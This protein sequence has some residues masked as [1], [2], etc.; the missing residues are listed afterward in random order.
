M[1]KTRDPNSLSWMPLNVPISTGI[2]SI[3]KRGF[4]IKEG[5]IKY[6]HGLRGIMKGFFFPLY[7]IFVLFF[8]HFLVVDAMGIGDIIG[9]TVFLMACTLG[10]YLHLRGPILS[11]F[12]IN[13][14]IILSGNNFAGGEP[15]YIEGQQNQIPMDSI[16]KII[17]RENAEKF[18]PSTKTDFG[19]LFILIESSF[20]NKFGNVFVINHFAF[21]Q[22]H[23]LKDYLDGVLAILGNKIEI[24]YQSE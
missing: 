15:F 6:R 24:D 3:L 23:H 12:D 21:S 2:L 16:K 7:V 20:S 11:S 9:T 1:N 4:Y 18:S 17:I 22:K 19:G 14:A 13:N 5:V 8:P 10:V